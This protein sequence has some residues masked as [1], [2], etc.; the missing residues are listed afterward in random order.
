MQGT[1]SLRPSCRPMVDLPEPGK[2]TRKQ[3]T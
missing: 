1:P 3:F 2:P